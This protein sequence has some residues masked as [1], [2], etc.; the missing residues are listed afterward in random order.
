VTDR[1]IRFS[2][3]QRFKGCRRSW[4]NSFYLG[5]TKPTNPLAP[6]T[7]KRDVGTICD[8]AIRE[9]YHGGVPTL[10]THAR[11]KAELIEEIG[12]LPKEWEAVYSLTERMLEGYEEWLEEE[13]ADAGERTVG[14]EIEL[15]TY[16]GKI[17]G[18]D[19][20]LVI[21]ID[22][23]VIDAWCEW[24]I[25]DT[26]TVDQF[27][28]AEVFAIDDQLTTYAW[29]WSRETGIPISR[30]RH[31]M[32]RKVQRTGTAKPP[33]YARDTINL[34]EETL[35]ATQNK[36]Y[37]VLEDMVRVYQQL[38]RF[39]GPEDMKI[40]A[41]RSAYPR[42]SKD[43]SW[44]CDFLPICAAHDDGSDLAGLRNE[45]YVPYPTVRRATA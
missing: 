39:H 43:C 13:G 44:W 24:I 38:D 7:G 5:L 18:D 32:L 17:A 16:I 12:P 14:T 1:Y 28:K 11:M 29:V 25:D 30:V 20:Y 40:R 8:V 41:A 10:E 21:H 23:V 37:G 36:L 3:T 4:L 26:K 19:V 27:Q 45:L 2:E 6:A 9:F 33:F 35:T 22:R 31:N 34:N 42:P 15:T